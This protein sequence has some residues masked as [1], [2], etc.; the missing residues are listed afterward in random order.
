MSSSDELDIE[1]MS[2]GDR[3]DPALQM[4]NNELVPTL[5]YDGY[6]DDVKELEATLFKQGAD[7]YWFV[8]ILFRVQQKQEMHEGDWTHPQLLQLDR[9]KD[10]VNYP[11]WEEDFSDAETTHLESGLLTVAQRREWFI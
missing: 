8:T 1:W 4:I 2:S 7:D 6:Q 5:T 11:G 9:L 3:S 10:V